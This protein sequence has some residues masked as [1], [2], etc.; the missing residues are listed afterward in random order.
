MSNILNKEW[1]TIDS[2][3][4][5]TCKSEVKYMRPCLDSE[6]YKKIDEKI[7]FYEAI[8][9][10]Q[11]ETIFDLKQK[12]RLFNIITKQLNEMV[13]NLNSQILTLKNNL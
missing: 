6:Y 13:E 8:V 4:C 12:I 9:K 10:E 3:M 5:G 7:D 1:Y 2:V 11:K